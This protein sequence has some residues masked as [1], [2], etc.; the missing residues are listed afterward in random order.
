MLVFTLGFP[1]IT[2]TMVS[3]W[4]P[5]VALRISIPETGVM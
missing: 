1:V 5:R 4:E 3:L 2:M